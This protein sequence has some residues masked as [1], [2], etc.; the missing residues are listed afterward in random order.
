MRP[1][2]PPHPG[3]PADDTSGFSNPRLT[4]GGSDAR[5]RPRLSRRRG[6]GAEVGCGD[7][8]SQHTLAAVAHHMKRGRPRYRPCHRLSV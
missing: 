4:R 6:R 2:T 7:L 3:D 5:S 8:D 1:R